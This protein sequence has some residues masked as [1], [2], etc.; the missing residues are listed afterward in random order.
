LTNVPVLFNQSANTIVTASADVNNVEHEVDYQQIVA[1]LTHVHKRH[2]KHEDTK[3]VDIDVTEQSTVSLE[4]DPL[5]KAVEDYFCDVIDSGQPKT[6]LD[7]FEEKSLDFDPE[8]WIYQV[9]G[10]YQALDDQDKQFF[11]LEPHGNN[12]KVYTGNF[13]INDITLGLR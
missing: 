8:V 4:K 12:D 10:G 11:A 5:Q 2:A 9:I 3:P 7:Y 6:A 13:Y 1:S